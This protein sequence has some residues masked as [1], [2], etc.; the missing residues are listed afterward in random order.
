MKIKILQINIRSLPFN[1]ILLENFASSNN[2]DI[3][4]LCETWLNQNEKIYIKNYNAFL[5]NRIDG[6][7]GTAIFIK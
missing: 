5:N 6:Y 7:G 2:I 3:L 1:K 4:V